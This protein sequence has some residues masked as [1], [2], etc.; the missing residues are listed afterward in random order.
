M[1]KEE[2]VVTRIVTTIA[3]VEAKDHAEMRE[4]HR[5]G[6]VDEYLAI[7]GSRKEQ[8][9]YIYE[10]DEVKVDIWGKDS[11]IIS[12]VILELDNDDIN[13]VAE[14]YLGKKLS[15]T[16]CQ[17]VLTRLYKTTELPRDDIECAID[18]V[19]KERV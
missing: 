9:E 8:E 11:P 5:E 3:I 16:Q 15:N 2:Y 13:L 14:D 12:K 4:L 7:Y 10:V 19:L 17:E 18:Y 1:S 6:I